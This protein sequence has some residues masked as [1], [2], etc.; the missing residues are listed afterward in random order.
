MKD[1]IRFKKDKVQKP[2]LGNYKE[3]EVRMSLGGYIMTALCWMVIGIMYF[4]Y[5]L[6]THY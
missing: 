1:Y 5:V 2:N 4:I 3:Y 6:I